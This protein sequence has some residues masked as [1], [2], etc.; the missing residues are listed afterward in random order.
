MQVS[1]G[2][3]KKLTIGRFCSIGLLSAAGTVMADGYELEAVYTGEISNN[4]AGGTSRGSRYLDNLDLMLSLDLSEAFSAGRGTVF[5]HGLYNNSATFAD[6]LVGD[7][8]G[9]SNID[10]AYGVRLFQA[11]YEIQQGAWSL[12]SGLYDLNS[13]FDAHETGGLFLNS[14]HGI[15]AEFAQTGR[16]GPSIFPVSSLALRA[17]WQSER[18]SVRLAVLD[19]VPGDT[20]DASSNKV[21]LSSAD[22]ALIVLEMDAVADS[23]TR[24]WAGHWQYT[25]SFAHL[26]YDYRS[27]DNDGWYLGAERNFDLAGRKAS[28]FIR[29]GTA[30]SDLNSL[31][32][33]FGAGIVVQAPFDR[34]PDDQ[35]GLAIASA[36][37]G[38][39]Y[40]D[41]LLSSGG[42]SGKHETIWEL[43]YRA[44][45]NNHFVVQPDIQ[46][47]KNP[48]MDA[49]LADAV[50]IALRFE[51]RY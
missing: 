18:L 41:A 30:N 17:S 11:W 22:G 25:G 29:Y 36:G 13:E 26:T 5:L 1:V 48:A 49:T 9:T 40:L 51:L 32:D 37:A 44:T 27:N 38:D 15:G 42:A 23:S 28:A 16:N 21:R 2:E 6:E 43:T 24:L 34:R 19:G 45:V 33:Y 14:S 3:M 39:A 4:V 31:E 35:V 10:A 8:Q 46:F 7:L 47:I 20:G 12:R 50:V